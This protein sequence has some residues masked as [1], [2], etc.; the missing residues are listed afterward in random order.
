MILHL[1]AST[2]A[3][4]YAIFD[5]AAIPTFVGADVEEAFETILAQKD[6]GN[7]ILYSDS[8]DGRTLLRVCVDE[9]P[10][11]DLTLRASNVVRGGLCRFPS[12]RICFTGVEDVQ[13]C[14]QQPAGNASAEL[15]PGTYG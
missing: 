2:T 11:D 15:P 5:P 4:G 1:R 8:F 10:A 9:D 3:A 6:L 12:G 14:Q 7:L 13:R